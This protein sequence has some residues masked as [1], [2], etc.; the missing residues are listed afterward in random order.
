MN[1]KIPLRK[2]TG[3]RENKPK[4]ELI[5]IVKNKEK[6]VMI[7]TTGKLN[8]RGAYVCKDQGCFENI[9]KTRALD[10]ALGTKLS[11]EFYDEVE[12]IIKGNM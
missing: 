2:C 6:G 8:G 11:E 4:N 10:R 5:R 9:V 1:K 7:D 12:D 3:C